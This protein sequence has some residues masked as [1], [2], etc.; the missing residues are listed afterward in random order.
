M[1][2]VC[3]ITHRTPCK[4]QGINKF[5]SQCNIKQHERRRIKTRWETILT[6]LS[7][8]EWGQLAVGCCSHSTHHHKSGQNSTNLQNDLFYSLN[9]VG[10]LMY[11]EIIYVVSRALWAIILCYNVFLIFHYF[12][13]N[14]F[15]DTNFSFELLNL[16]NVMLQHIV[17]NSFDLVLL[18]KIAF[19]LITG[20]EFIE[21]DQ[22][23]IRI[24]STNWCWSP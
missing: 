1:I 23:S 7:G 18:M 2:W 12:V 4:I 11:S 14:F 9:I 3:T 22:I 6:L 21:Y 15:F 19:S 24:I 16:R 13:I 17:K 10:I 5:H 8:L 20:M